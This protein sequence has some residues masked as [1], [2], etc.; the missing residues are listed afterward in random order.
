MRKFALITNFNIPEKAEAAK[1]V[2]DEIFAAGGE[3]LIASFNRERLERIGTQ[4]ERIVY[5]PLESVYAEAEAI[6]VLGGDGTIL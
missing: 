4:D 3:I 5:L 1:R 2:A 6:I